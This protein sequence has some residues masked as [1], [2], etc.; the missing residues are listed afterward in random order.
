MS[1]LGHYVYNIRNSPRAGQGNS[2]D[3]KLT[4]KNIEYWVK[5]HRAAIVDEMAEAGKRLDNS[6]M[7]DLGIVP[8]EDIDMTDQD[9]NK[10]L[11][12]GCKI[13]KV[14]IPKPIST[15]LDGAPTLWVGFIDK[16]TP[17]A[18]SHPNAV[19]FRERGMFGKGM[20]R[21]W[22]IGDRLYIS[23]KDTFKN[24]KY[25]NIRGI[26]QDPTEAFNYATPGCDKNC[27]NKLTDD[28]PLTDAIYKRIVERIF[29]LELNIVANTNT[30]EVNDG[31]DSTQKV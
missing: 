30:D 24:T 7:Q 31:R 1:L 8:L 25:V 29:R 6:L 23:F 18:I 12:W 15:K 21:A 4:P 19:F 27:F 28:Y 16:L 17:I 5:Y 2:D 9:C 22:L 26:F 11:Q 3:N 13:K 10:Y 14:I 20:N